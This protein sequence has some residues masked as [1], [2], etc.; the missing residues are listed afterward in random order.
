M[1]PI[2]ARILQNEISE[3]SNGFVTLRLNNQPSSPVTINLTPSDKQF[4]IGD[5]G[6]GM[7]DS[8]VFT[9]KNWDVIQSVE[10]RSVN[11]E[12]VEDITTSQLNILST[13]DDS[14]FNKVSNTIHID[15]V[16]EDLPTAT[17]TPIVDSSEEAEPG[18]FRIN[19]SDPAPSSAGSNGVVVQYQIDSLNL[20]QRGGLPYTPDVKNINKITQ[21]PG[22]TTGEVRIAPGQSFSDVLV[23][24]IDD[25]YADSIDKSF[26]VSLLKSDNNSYEIKNDENNSTT[27]NIINNDIAGIYT[28]VSGEF[29]RVSENPVVPEFAQ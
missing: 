17:I 25:R 2:E 21:S 8:L 6:V 28:Q 3:A 1:F 14:N 29:L 4:T 13:S 24:P 9:P 7:Q 27:V 22:V 16:S 15:I 5:R 23:V 26:S 11:D 10:I 12:L 18:R 19:L 20:D